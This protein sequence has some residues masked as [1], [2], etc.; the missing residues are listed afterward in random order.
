MFTEPRMQAVYDEVI[1]KTPTSAVMR[2]ARA[3]ACGK[4]ID[5]YSLTE[6]AGAFEDGW[7]GAAA[8]SQYQA[9]RKLALSFK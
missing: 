7:R 1:L 9:L 5:A 6:N 2:G 3:Y 4:G 8:D